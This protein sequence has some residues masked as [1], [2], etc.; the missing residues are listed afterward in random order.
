MELRNGHGW[1]KGGVEGRAQKLFVKLVFFSTL[2]VTEKS[3]MVA[4]KKV[5][6]FLKSALFEKN[7]DPLLEY[8]I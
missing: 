5:D 8:S 4:Q 3:I 7:L 2:G 6:K 1:I